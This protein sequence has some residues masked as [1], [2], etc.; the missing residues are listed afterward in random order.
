MEHTHAIPETSSLVNVPLSSTPFDVSQE[1]AEMQPHTLS[2]QLSPPHSTSQISSDVFM[3]DNMEISNSPSLKLMGEPKIIIDT[4]H[5]EEGDLLE[6]QS[7]ISSMVIDIVIE[8]QKPLSQQPSIDTSSTTV[9]PSMDNASIVNPLT[10]I[11]YPLTTKPSM[12]IPSS[13][14]PSLSDTIIS[15]LGTSNEEQIVISS[16]LGLSEKEKKRV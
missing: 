5:S 15:N 14:N 1:N 2:I 8:H 7:F 11:H 12:D 4:Y 10:D 13:S 3:I 9:Y 6:Y 16:L